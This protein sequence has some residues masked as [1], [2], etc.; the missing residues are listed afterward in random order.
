MNRTLYPAVKFK[1][2]VKREEFYSLDERLQFIL[3]DCAR[4]VSN[5]GYDFIITGMLSDLDTDI[6][7]KRVSAS[8]REGRASDIRT[9]SWPEEFIA[10]FMSF[11]EAAHGKQGAISKSDGKRRIAVRHVG[12]ADH[13]HI[14]VSK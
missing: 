7:L 6:K 5:S 4:W 11:I 1:E 3:E 12:T 10:K 2:G 13:I 9:K 14:Q 8:H